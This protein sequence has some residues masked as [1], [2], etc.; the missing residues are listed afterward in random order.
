M[1]NFME[2]YFCWKTCIAITVKPLRYCVEML[3]IAFKTKWEREKKS[4]IW[5]ESSDL[6]FIILHFSFIHNKCHNATFEI[7]SRKDFFHRCLIGGARFVY[8]YMCIAK[9]KLNQNYKRSLELYSVLFMFFQVFAHLKSYHRARAVAQ[10]KIRFVYTHHKHIQRGEAEWKKK[11]HCTVLLIK[12]NN[13]PS[14]TFYEN[15]V[16][17][18]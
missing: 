11:K 10:T 1:I 5:N 2:S 9:I 16:W 7:Y 6:D 15:T 17:L 3:T 12:G 4:E 14:L 18:N 8:C 13:F